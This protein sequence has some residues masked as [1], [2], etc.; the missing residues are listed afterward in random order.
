[1]KEYRSQERDQIRLKRQAKTAGDFY[2]APEAKLA[3][4]IRI[5]GINKM[6]PKPRKIL[7]LLRLYRINTA[8]FVKLNKVFSYF[9]DFLF[10]RLHCR[11]FNGLDLSSLGDTLT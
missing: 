7:Q 11:C 3:F 10:E 1:M 9:V 4:V 2:V 8:V 6:A 5:K